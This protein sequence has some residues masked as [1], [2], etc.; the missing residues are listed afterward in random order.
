MDISPSMKEVE[1]VRLYIV[2]R[3]IESH[4][5]DR[6]QAFRAAFKDNAQLKKLTIESHVISDAEAIALAAVIPTMANLESFHL[7]CSGCLTWVGRVALSAA[8]Q[9]SKMLED[10][11][12]STGTVPSEVGTEK[13]SLMLYSV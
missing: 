12:L 13:P 4:V 10:I 11:Q 1:E 9:D 8:A 2:D 6:S 7:H 3:E 5:M